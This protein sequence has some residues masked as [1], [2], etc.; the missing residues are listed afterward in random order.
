MFRATDSYTMITH[1][2]TNRKAIKQSNRYAWFIT[3]QEEMMHDPSA[4]LTIE[5]M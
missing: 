2:K 5:H 3:R 4:N 1:T